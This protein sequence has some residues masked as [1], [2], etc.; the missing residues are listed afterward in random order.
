MYT[1]KTGWMDKE[2]MPPYTIEKLPDEPIVIITLNES[3]SVTAH[4]DQ[5]ILDLRKTFDAQPEPVIYIQD[6]L[7]LTI[8]FSEL[9]ELAS[10]LTR[11]P[12]ALFRHPKIKKIISVTTDKALLLT[13]KGLRTDLFGRIDITAVDTLDK[14]LAL[15]RE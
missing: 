11:T 1:K 14:A 8:T 6:L 4:Q 9:A 3:F 2:M 7:L 10:L 13:Y 15:A 5:S 12:T